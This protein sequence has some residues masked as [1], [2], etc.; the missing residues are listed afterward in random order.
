[1]RI[2]NNYVSVNI[3]NFLPRI[4]HDSTREEIIKGLFAPQKYISS[5]YF[6][7]EQGSRLFKAITGLD[8]YYL[9]RTEKKI[10]N[11]DPAIISGSRS[12]SSIIEFGSGDCSKISILLRSLIDQKSNGITYMPFDIS[13][14]AIEE[15]IQCLSQQFNDVSI[16][17]V[18]ADFFSQLH[19]LPNEGSARLFCFFGST[20]GNF[21]PGRRRDFI[22]EISSI[23]E[24]DDV[25]LLGADMVK[26][27]NVME[28]AYNDR[29]GVTA[30]FNKNIL[31]VVNCILNTDFR[32]GQFE[33]L[34]FY[35]DSS[36]RI[37]MHLKALAD[38]E[39]KSPL[40]REPLFMKKG[41]TIHT[42]NSY[43]FRMEEFNE[44]CRVSGLS[45]SD[46]YTDSNK[47]FSVLKFVRQ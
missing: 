10:L 2:N 34:A 12:F 31:N 9:T 38:L 19:I 16:E 18:V 20:L 8:E 1:M 17:G 45:I 11:A 6:Y 33:H 13:Q 7:D 27:I 23:M 5:K 29:R 22:S 3:R 46:V 36:R 43:K 41:E 24:K 44:L 21:E 25:F 30:A 14:S 28:R 40:F 35:N 4:G 42:E 37:E 32:T 39:I 26:D 15:A 47:W